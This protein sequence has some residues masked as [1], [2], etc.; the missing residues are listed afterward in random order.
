MVPIYQAIENVSNVQQHSHA[1]V[2]LKWNMFLPGGGQWFLKIV[3]MV[4]EYF[5]LIIIIWYV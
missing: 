3:R 5:Y 1:K 2:A 4:K